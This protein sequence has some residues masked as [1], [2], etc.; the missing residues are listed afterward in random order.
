MV[1][2]YTLRDLNGHFNAGGLNKHA[3]PHR[4]TSCFSGAPYKETFSSVAHPIV[5]DGTRPANVRRCRRGITRTLI[6]ALI[7]LIESN[8]LAVLVSFGLAGII[9]R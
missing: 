8:A 6:D 7:L 1:T 9:T 2:N 5:A 4:S 3:N